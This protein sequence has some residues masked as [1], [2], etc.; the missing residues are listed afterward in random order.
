VTATRGHCSA[1]DDHR[2]PCHYLRLASTSSRNDW[3][4]FYS[5]A[6]S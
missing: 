6:A 2:R 5:A 3:V 4:S 1:G